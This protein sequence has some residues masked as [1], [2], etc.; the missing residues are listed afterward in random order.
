MAI[1]KIAADDDLKEEVTTLLKENNE[2]LSEFFNK[3]ETIGAIL[4]HIHLISF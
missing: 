1:E 4:K 2:A 3:P